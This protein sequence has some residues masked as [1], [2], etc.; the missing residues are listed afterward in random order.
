MMRPNRRHADRVDGKVVILPKISKLA[1]V[2]GL[3]FCGS[4]REGTVNRTAGTWV[5]C[6]CMEDGEEPPPMKDGP[7]TGVDVGVGMMAVC[8]DGATIENPKALA[9]GLKRL[10]RLDK[11]I[12]RSRDVHGRS[13]DSNRRERLYA[14]RRNLHARI[15]NVRNDNH[16]KATTAIAK[17][18]G[19]VEVETLN[20]AGMVRN[21]RLA[22]TVACGAVAGMLSADRGGATAVTG[23]PT[24]GVFARPTGNIAS[25][26]RVFPSYTRPTI[27]VRARSWREGLTPLC[28]ALIVDTIT[29]VDLLVLACI[30]VHCVDIIAECESVGANRRNGSASART[31]G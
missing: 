18:C 22:A 8:S 4:I 23:C 14:K 7:T 1:M 16:H 15:V 25:G 10:R 9:S 6:F 26:L 17:S 28:W 13:N 29:A 19:R 5:A 3:R 24:S 20:V 12:A 21:R 27:S 11:A 30:N 2:E 31:G